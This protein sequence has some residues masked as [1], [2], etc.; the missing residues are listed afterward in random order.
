[1]AF[2]PQQAQLH[3]RM[4]VNTQLHLARVIINYGFVHPGGKS[5]EIK[6]RAMA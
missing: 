6:L 5:I 3:L 1:M 2:K 4:L